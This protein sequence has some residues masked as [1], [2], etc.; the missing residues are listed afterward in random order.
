MQVSCWSRLLFGRRRSR[1]IQSALIWLV[2]AC[3]LPA[4]AVATLFIVRSYERER[5]NI[6]RDTIGTA[7]ALMQAVDGELKGAQ[8]ALE[9]LATSSSLASGDLAGF[10][11][12]AQKALHGL[13]GKNIMLVGPGGTQVMNTLR[14]FGEPLP[15]ESGPAQLLR[16]LETGRP[17]ISDLFSGTITKQPT[18]AI[19]VP[20]VSNGKI[21]YGLAMGIFPERLA[22]VLRQENMPSTWI[23]AIFDRN[24]TIVARTH[25]AEQ[26]V[27][28]KA[29]PLLLRRMSEIP[30]GMVETET[31][32]GVPSL[33]S[34]SRSAVSGW[35]VAI[36]VPTAEALGALRRSLGLSVAGA[37]LLLLVCLSLAQLISRRIAGAIET[38]AGRA[39]ALGAN[40]AIS[41]PPLGIKEADEAAQ[42]MV[43]ASQVLRRR[44]VER[45]EAERTERRL[46]VAK[47]AA[48]EANQA[49]SDFLALMSHEIRTPMTSVIGMTELL[50]DSDL[51]AR[52]R[53]Q[54][55]LLKDAGELLLAIIDDLLDMS[56]IEAGKLEL[57]HVPLSPSDVAQAVLAVLRP[58][59]AA[60]NI[61][62]RSEFAADLPALID[63]DPTRLRQVLLNLLSNALKFTERGSV[64]LTV[65]REPEPEATRL[66][67]EVRDTG[68][69]IDTAQQ[70][71]LFQRFSQLGARGDRPRGTGLGLAISRQLVEAMG[72]TIGVKS[73][74]AEGSVF[75]FTIPYAEMRPQAARTEEP[76]LGAG[77][78]S[79]ILVA[80]DQYMIRELME[81]ILTDAGHDVVLVH[82]GVEAVEAV[83]QDNFDVVLMDIEMPEMDG[84]TATRRI[85]QIGKPIRNIPIVALTAYA[86]A[87][88]VERC[89]AAGANEHLSKPVK[90]KELLHVVAKWSGA[91]QTPS[92]AAP[93][94]AAPPPIIDSTI[95]EDLENHLGQSQVIRLVG[96]FCDQ[97][98]KT[99][100]DITST[101]DRRLIAQQA[102]ALISLAGNLGCTE[103]MIHSR[104][105]MN[106]ARGETGDLAPLVAETA[107]AAHRALS[108]MQDRYPP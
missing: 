57:A 43:K 21:I 92:A 85:R 69:G 26:H 59:A 53:H 100:S 79:R 29:T 8:S 27:G 15:A 3:I 77:S 40:E 31:L 9:V 5:A 75:W 24:G 98:P 44:A 96:L 23:A 12:Q 82:N 19:E 86:M 90:R 71:R 84:I 1:T 66:R 46:L 63:G 33:L 4:C 30:E 55:T 6:E 2:V 80:E 108:A 97:L 107:A 60:R 16:P 25:V 34:F 58:Q 83:E 88:D 38:L 95:L 62:L 49:K 104:A 48:E 36:G 11:D 42:A 99:I 103:L 93:A 81:T 94:D 37:G 45:D 47:H 51:T 87:D 105:L 70:G 17:V 39:A 56:K 74:R 76:A 7:R 64:V 10:Y 20:V 61:E 65:A 50:L 32:E 72:G 78:R 89:R 13:A 22:E 35:A 101:T 102:H 28:R 14:P 67:F 91:A 54:A 68:I 18:I 73:R 41:I 106:A 52:Q